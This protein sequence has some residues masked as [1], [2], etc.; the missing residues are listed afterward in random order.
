M[1]SDLQDERQKLLAELARLDERLLGMEL[2]GLVD[3]AAEHIETA[4]KLLAEVHGRDTAAKRER[5]ESA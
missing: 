5:D 3:Q 1:T 4:K 2:C